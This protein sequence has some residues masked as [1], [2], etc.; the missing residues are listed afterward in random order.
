MLDDYQIILNHLLSLGVYT[1][2]RGEREL[3]D[4][5]KPWFLKHYRGRY[6]S[7]YLDSAASF[8]S[9]QIES[10]RS[11]GGDITSIP[12]I[13]KPIARLNNDLYTI[14]EV[15]SD[16]WMLLRITIAPRELVL[17]PIK[18]NH[19]HFSEWVSNRPGTLVILPD[20][21]RLCFTPETTPPIS[22]ESVA[23]DLNFDRVT[24]ARTDG[25]MKQFG[26]HE[27]TDIQRHHR[28]KRN[29]IQ[30]TLRRNPKKAERLLTEQ[31]GRERNRVKDVLHKKIHG[32]HNEFL[33]FVGNRTLGFE[34]LSSCTNDILRLDNG[35]RFNSKMSSW[36]HSEFRRIVSIIIQATG[37][38]TRG[39]RL[40]SVR[41]I[42]PL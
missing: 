42:T 20:G 33:K 21:I 36:I 17:L 14:K 16:G 18:V 2:S 30:S 23:V 39:G 1:K 10:W 8:A 7:H 32:R 41:L 3:R 28:R 13:R 34:D 25:R 11:L 15:R 27:I 26:I 31:A 24:M 38:T 37:R 29:A 9:Q 22:S 5:A 19:R 12:H 6:A 35:K 40:G 4:F